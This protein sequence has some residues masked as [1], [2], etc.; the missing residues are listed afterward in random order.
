VGLCG[1]K[2]ENSD[3]GESGKIGTTSNMTNPLDEALSFENF[4]SGVRMMQHHKN[5]S[6]TWIGISYL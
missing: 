4:D 6:E 1:A 5:S 2:L 3:L